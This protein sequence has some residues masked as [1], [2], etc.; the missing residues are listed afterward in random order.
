MKTLAFDTSTAFASQ[1]F[2]PEP[3][4]SALVRA[5][6]HGIFIIQDGLIVY[7][8]PAGLR[9]LGAESAEQVLG[10]PTTRFQHPDF[11]EATRRRFAELLRNGGEAPLVEQKLMRLDGR[12]I[13]VEIVAVA[14]SYRGLPAIQAVIRDISERKRLTHALQTHGRLTQALRTEISR[15]GVLHAFLDN[16]QQSFSA[17]GAALVLPG[18]NGQPFTNGYT[19]G[20][21]AEPSLLSL[22]SS[23]DAMTGILETWVPGRT[24]TLVDPLERVKRC[25]QF[26]GQVDPSISLV[27]FPLT[28]EGKLVA[29][30]WLARREPFAEFEISL[31]ESIRTLAGINI[32]RAGLADN[33]RQ[34]LHR[35]ESLQR[36]DRSINTSL[37]LQTTL[38]LL[39]EQV[40][41]S[42]QIDAVSILLVDELGQLRYKA[43]R[44]F[45]T[46]LF[47]TA[48]VKLDDPWAGQAA[49]KRKLV[50]V[51]LIKPVGV[52]PLDEMVA[53]EGFTSYFAAPLV[54]RG[55]FVGVLEMF[56]RQPLDP[57]QGWFDFLLTVAEQ[58]A[59]A[60]R[61]ADQFENL[62]RAKAEMEIAYQATLSGWVRALDLRDGETGEH[63]QRVTQLCVDL[64]RALNYPQDLLPQ[65]WRGAMLHDIG[66]MA[67][68][69]SIL[70]K[71]GPLSED[72]WAVMKT[73]PALA[74]QLLAPIDF[75]RSALDIP[76]CHHEHWD[77][78]G[79]PEG[80][81]GEQIPL[82]ARIFAVV[83]VWDALRSDR[84]YRKA[85]TDQQALD[86]VREQKGK[87][88]D[89]KAVETFEQMVFSG[90][91]NEPLS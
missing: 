89:P 29:V 45:R 7:S 80:L 5:T 48:D 12:P 70:R 16:M 77:G 15:E 11:H 65:L 58:A 47:E 42:L 9:L 49:L 30:L 53:A 8:N 10:Q 41:S 39:L 59:I 25:T 40:S 69:D 44:G 83:D 73:H 67:I 57:D 85:W 43:G 37:N 36:I 51:P 91:R 34:S 56:H 28:A 78:S 71:P 60:I 33:L 82:A 13:S 54:S 2:Q 32:Q 20:L 68:P 38:N 81:A 4:V 63:T 14:A 86:Y 6:P 19:F 18:E 52:S 88:F 27:C 64:A 17:E 74:R 76:Y 50:K 35:M 84:P 75:L 62:Q 26:A 55:D 46:G 23:Q 87:M 31:L 61:N 1:S 3:D 21:L 24:G 72:E 79:Y 90:E 22:I 66:K